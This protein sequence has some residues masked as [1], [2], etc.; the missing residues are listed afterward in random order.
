MIGILVLALASISSST[1]D[2]SYPRRVGPGRRSEQRMAREVF[3]DACRVP[4]HQLLADVLV[5]G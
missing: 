2:S 4:R 5:Y 1:E 3:P